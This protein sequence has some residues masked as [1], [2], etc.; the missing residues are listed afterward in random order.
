[1]KRVVIHTVGSQRMD[2]ALLDA[3]ARY[4]YL[5][6]Y[7][8]LIGTAVLE[9]SDGVALDEL[10]AMGLIVADASGIARLAS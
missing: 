7:S 10:R 1:M 5:V 3:L 8:S 6:S 2:E 9:V 4:G